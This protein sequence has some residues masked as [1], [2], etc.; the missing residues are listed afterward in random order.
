MVKMNKN[1]DKDCP[2][3]TNCKTIRQK[4][5]YVLYYCKDMCYHQNTNLVVEEY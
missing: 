1:F 2:I 5:T 3:T 4:G